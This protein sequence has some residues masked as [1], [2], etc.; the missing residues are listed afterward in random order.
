MRAHACRPAAYSYRTI[1]QAL[2]DRDVDLAN[3]EACRLAM[4]EAFGVEPD[5]NWLAARN[6][7][8]DLRD[9]RRIAE[10]ARTIARHTCIVGLAGLFL[11]VGA[12]VAFAADGLTPAEWEVLRALAAGAVGIAIVGAAAWWI[13]RFLAAQIDRRPE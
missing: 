3:L 8:S 11:I 13:E 10:S 9:E 12:N 6:H 7:A 4:V 5:V 2:A 1:G